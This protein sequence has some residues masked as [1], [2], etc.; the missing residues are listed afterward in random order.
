MTAHLSRHKSRSRQIIHSYEAKALR[1]RSFGS[2]CI[3][4]LTAFFG[5]FWFLLINVI[6]FTAWIV[7]NLGMLR[8]VSVFDP[9]PFV[10]LITA[11]SLEAII[12]TTIVL[13]T[14]QKQNQIDTIRDELQLQVEIITEKE[15][16]KVLKLLKLLLQKNE[17]K[18]KDD[19]LDEMLNQL[20]RSYIE[21]KLEQQLTKTASQQ[22]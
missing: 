2:K 8:D 3:D 12:L 21:R 15:L 13:I 16:S 5:S 10:L 18:L 11:V 7:I 20:D 14:Q 17:I 19:E 9:Y 4:S 22:K 6:I 1:K